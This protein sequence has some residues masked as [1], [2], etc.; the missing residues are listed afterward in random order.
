MNSSINFQRPLTDRERALL[1]GTAYINLGSDYEARESD[2][3]SIVSYPTY[4][5]MYING[6]E[7]ARE[8]RERL[9]IMALD[10]D[11]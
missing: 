8:T 1:C 10:S 9:A 4:A 2:D 11:L 3:I 6:I 5:S 7:R